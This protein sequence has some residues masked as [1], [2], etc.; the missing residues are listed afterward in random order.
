MILL[1]LLSL[2]LLISVISLLFV[3]PYCC[4]SRSLFYRSYP[5]K[6]VGR[7]LKFHFFFFL[8]YGWMWLSLDTLLTYFNTLKKLYL[9]LYKNYYRYERNVSHGF[10]CG[11]QFPLRRQVFYIFNVLYFLTIITWDIYYMLTRFKLY[12]LFFHTRFPM[13]SLLS[14]IST[15]FCIQYKCI[16]NAYR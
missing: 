2:E 11:F 6:Y 12:I 4:C 16:Q 5:S 1:S 13:S 3:L 10:L 15:Q 14:N 8:L 7:L 9:I